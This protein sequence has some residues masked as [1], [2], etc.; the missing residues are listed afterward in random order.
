M[1]TAHTPCSRPV[2]PPAEQWS[3]I[4]K[5]RTHVQMDRK[6]HRPFGRL[7]SR[8]PQSQL[9]GKTAEWQSAQD[10]LFLYALWILALAARD[11]LLATAAGA[12][13]ASSCF[14]RESKG[15]AMR[16]LRADLTTWGRWCTY[17]ITAS[18]QWPSRWIRMSSGLSFARAFSS[19][20][21]DIVSVSSDPCTL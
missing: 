1:G 21:S 9:S 12:V 6:P 14:I 5:C 13:W 4:E 19:S 15:S 3:L 11:T 16:S 10:T 2:W 7:W 8:S 17:H 20:H 18:W